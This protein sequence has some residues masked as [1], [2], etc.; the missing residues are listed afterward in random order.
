MLHKASGSVPV[1]PQPRPRP[2][3]FKSPSP[4]SPPPKTGSSVQAAAS[5][6]KAAGVVK[7]EPDP[8]QL[9]YDVLRGIGEDIVSPYVEWQQL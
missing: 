8:E 7:A 3:A 9:L 1:T 6:A 5:P 2:T 4:C